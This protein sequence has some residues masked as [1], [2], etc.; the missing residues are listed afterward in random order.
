MKRKNLWQSEHLT[1]KEKNLS[2]ATHLQ[3]NNQK[4]NAKNHG[5]RPSVAV[6]VIFNTFLCSGITGGVQLEGGALFFNPSPI[7]ALK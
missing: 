6:L 4:F 2:T 7:V 3:I 1:F 5:A